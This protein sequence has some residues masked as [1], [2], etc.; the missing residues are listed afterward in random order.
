MHS[1][2]LAVSDRTCSV[3]VVRTAA[4]AANP[5]QAYRPAA[6]LMAVVFLF[7]AVSNASLTSLT[8]WT[9]ERFGARLKARL[10][11]I[12]MAQDQVNKA[13]RYND[14]LLQQERC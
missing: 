5:M 3:Q 6:V 14:H 8:A 11:R 10:F 7:S 9:G 12:I 13:F 1:D 2:A 4:L